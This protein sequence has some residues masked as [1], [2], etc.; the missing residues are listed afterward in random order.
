[1]RRRVR[2]KKRK[3][4]NPKEEN[5]KKKNYNKTKSIHVIH[6]NNNGWQYSVS[7]VYLADIKEIQTTFQLNIQLQTA[8]HLFLKQIFNKFN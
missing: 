2:K 1:M 8:Y 6:K 7:N 5:T 3:G 4:M